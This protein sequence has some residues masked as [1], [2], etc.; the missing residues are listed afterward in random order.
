MAFLPPPVDFR[1]RMECPAC[2]LLTLKKE[3]QCV[4]CG[5][6]FPEEWRQ[7][8]KA[9]GRER[10][11]RATWAAVVIVP[12]LLVLLTLLFQRAGA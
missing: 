9:K 3:E 1:P 6:R 10:R 8:Q 4:H 7:R 12:A 11:R 2:G 5:Y